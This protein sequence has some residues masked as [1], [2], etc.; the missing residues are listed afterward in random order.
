M[1]KMICLALILS[2]I[3]IIPACKAK[4]TITTSKPSTSPANVVEEVTDKGILVTT[5][6]YSV[7]LPDV[8]K[9][10]YQIEYR[11]LNNDGYTLSF[12]EP[13][14]KE[15]C[16]GLIFDLTLVRPLEFPNNPL[17]TYLGSLHAPN[18]GMFAIGSRLP[19]DV[20]F[21]EEKMETYLQ[22]KDTYQ[23][24]IDS[25]EIVDDDGCFYPTGANTFEQRAKLT[26]HSEKG[27]AVIHTYL[28]EKEPHLKLEYLGVALED[29]QEKSS[30][31]NN[32]GYYGYHIWV[33]KD[34][35]GTYYGVPFKQQ[36][37]TLPVVCKMTQYPI[38]ESIWHSEE[39]EVIA[40]R[41][42][43]TGM[44]TTSDEDLGGYEELDLDLDGT[45]ELLHN[46]NSI[47]TV[48]GYQNRRVV[49]LDSFRYDTGTMAFYHTKPDPYEEPVYTDPLPG[50]FTRWVGGGQNHYGYLTLENGK[51]VN[52]L[53]WDENYSSL[54]DTPPT[55]NHTEDE[56]LIQA[57]IIAYE[58]I[59][60]ANITHVYKDTLKGQ[61]KDQQ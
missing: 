60:F 55:T 1:K 49:K 29:F 15:Q 52:T 54:P 12:I 47:L 30:Y 28:T 19:T 3:L 13:V 43:L 58:R 40:Y 11:E 23:E 8:W 14:S 22:M 21:I 50:L 61:V 6:Y 18:H 4:P 42:F 38:M 59:G 46:N 57:S 53:L 36:E 20:Q 37:G 26:T 34:Q 16:G 35:K 27:E 24:V 39:P 9:N 31:M 32:N 17:I 44:V 7:L 48:Y 41:N 56:K 10:N 45:K 51:L 5:K 2:I 25:L 33:P